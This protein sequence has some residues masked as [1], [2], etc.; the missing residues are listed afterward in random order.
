MPGRRLVMPLVTPT[1][2]GLVLLPM[3]GQYSATPLATRVYH[4]ELS[5]VMSER[6]WWCLCDIRGHT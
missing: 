2:H 1:R 3:L 4:S 5:R 6:P